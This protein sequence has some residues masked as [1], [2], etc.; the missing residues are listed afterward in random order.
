MYVPIWKL[1]SEGIYDLTFLRGRGKNVSDLLS[2]MDIVIHDCN[3][4][5]QKLKQEDL[6]FEPVCAVYS[7]SISKTQNQKLYSQQVSGV[8][9]VVITMPYH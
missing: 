2:K 4:S 9:N 5:T 8:Y 6:L 1:L 3:T 7:D